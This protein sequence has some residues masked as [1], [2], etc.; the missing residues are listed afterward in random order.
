MVPRISASKREKTH[1][2]IEPSNTHTTGRRR[3]KSD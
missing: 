3:S 1:S 2:R